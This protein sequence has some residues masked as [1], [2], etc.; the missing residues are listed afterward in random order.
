MDVENHAILPSDIVMP[1]MIN[2]ATPS[3]CEV[4][5]KA[6]A[7]AESDKAWAGVSV[8]FARV[9]LLSPLVLGV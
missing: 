1:K 8:S 7:P 6:A 3:P 5:V 9:L 2:V 4:C